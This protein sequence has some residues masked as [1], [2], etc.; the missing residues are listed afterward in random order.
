V[1]L[2]TGLNYKFP[3]SIDSFVFYHSRIDRQARSAKEKDMSS[4]KKAPPHED[5]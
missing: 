1:Q 2:T 5:A 3:N 4:Q